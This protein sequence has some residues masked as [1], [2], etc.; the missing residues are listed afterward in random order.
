MRLIT[1]MLTILMLA[2]C[3]VP[4]LAA[5][6]YYDD[7][8]GKFDLQ[9]K[10]GSGFKATVT[11]DT[12]GASLLSSLG[13]SL[14]GVTGEVTLIR[15]QRKPEVYQGILQMSRGET[16]LTDA[17]LFG[18]KEYAALQAD[19][20]ENS[21]KLPL[22]SATDLILSKE[23]D[24]GWAQMLM[25]WATCED[26]IWLAQME[27]AGEAYR[28]DF[29]MWLAKYAQ[30]NADA[31]DGAMSISYVIPAEDLKAEMQRLLAQLMGDEDMLA[32]LK[33]LVTE[34][35]AYRYLNPQWA[36]QYL[37]I[38]EGIVLE[39]QVEVTHTQS[40]KGELLST[41][42]V[43]PVPAHLEGEF[44]TF[45]M[46]ADDDHWYFALEGK[47][48]LS[49]RWDKQGEGSQSTA[50]GAL[51][52]S[53]DSFKAQAE[54]AFTQERKEWVDEEG[55]DHLT[56][57]WSLAVSNGN[58]EEEG[59][60]AF[61][62]LVLDYED[63]LRSGPDRRNATYL[64]MKISLKQGEGVDTLSLTGRTTGKW[65]L[66]S[67]NLDSAQD[68]TDKKPEEVLDLLVKLGEEVKTWAMP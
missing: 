30:V 62:P 26:E 43:L 5:D 53:L 2:S 11:G 17:M 34:E 68:L 65:D 66:I 47:N 20:L 7:L 9:I 42:V 6:K 57:R 41:R 4:G 52:V 12:Q 50:S 64:D 48:V 18:D 14:S 36:S 60:L 3:V 1:W 19:F 27:T 31:A 44:A 35:Q 55:N 67:T 16:V 24:Y 38:L 8:W 13:M 51:M 56:N 22:A 23:K 40:M 10:G 39:G 54:F 21:I 15:D 61:E 25:A 33:Q 63:A 59:Y 37:N 45:T 32:V 49:L 29:E 58:P 46:E 28:L